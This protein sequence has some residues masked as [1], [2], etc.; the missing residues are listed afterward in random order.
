MAENKIKDFVAP[1][2]TCVPWQVK[3]EEFGQL[4]G[5]EEI[6]KQEWEK[7]DGLAYAFIWFWVQR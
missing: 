1:A 4:A 6:V 5:N 7:L 2:G 3:K